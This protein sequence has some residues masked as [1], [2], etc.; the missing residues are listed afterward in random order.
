MVVQQQK[1]DI[2]HDIHIYYDTMYDNNDIIDFTTISHT[3]EMVSA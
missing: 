1:H 2:I 3:Q